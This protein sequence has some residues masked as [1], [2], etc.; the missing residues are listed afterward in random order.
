MSE[1][2]HEQAHPGAGVYIIVAA[3]LAVLTAMEITV[4]YVPPLKPVIV[5]LL[6]I[7]AAAKFSLIAM[8]FMHLKYD[9]WFLSGVFVFPLI[10][11]MVLLISLLLLFA[12]LTHHI[13]VWPLLTR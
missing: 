5:P 11:A 2:T 8:F 12:Y 1:A 13:A 10:I 9:S 7:L 6:L 3:F 4:F